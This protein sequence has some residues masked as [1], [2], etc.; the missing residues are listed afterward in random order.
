[1]RP[2]AEL[3]RTLPR[4]IKC[5]V[6]PGNRYRRPRNLNE[7]RQLSQLTN[8][9]CDDPDTSGLGPRY[10][11]GPVSHSAEWDRWRL[12]R[13]SP[14]KQTKTWS[15]DSGAN[16][17]GDRVCGMST[18]VNRAPRA[19]PCQR[20]GL[21]ADAAPGLEY[22]APER[23]SGVAVQQ[24]DQRSGLIGQPLALSQAVPVNVC[25]APS[26]HAKHIGMATA[27][28]HAVPIT[29]ARQRCGT[30]FRRTRKMRATRPVQNEAASFRVRSPFV[31]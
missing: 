9:K 3:V 10:S 16:G 18:D 15:N 29:R 22:R 21:S 25:S 1:M 12:S 11:P 2:K 30:P 8:G 23:V 20:H 6:P 13:N 4:G 14:T 7:V 28:S 5:P 24:F 17:R 19:L 31:N 26:A 27:R